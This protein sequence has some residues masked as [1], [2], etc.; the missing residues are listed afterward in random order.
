VKPQAINLVCG[1]ASGCLLG[2]F[3]FIVGLK[4]HVIIGYVKRACSSSLFVCLLCLFGLKS[5]CS[6]DE[7]LV[8]DK[9]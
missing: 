7:N 5:F 8:L 3:A 6:E 4:L 2:C 1:G 9:F